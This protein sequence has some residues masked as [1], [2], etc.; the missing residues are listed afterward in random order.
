MARPI[1]R[2]L[3]DPMDREVL[4]SRRS[5]GM[6]ADGLSYSVAGDLEKQMGQALA[7]YDARR[8][9]PRNDAFG[10][11]LEEDSPQN[12]R[13]E[14]IDPL[15]QS[16][17]GRS[18]QQPKSSAPRT[19]KVKGKNGEDIVIAIDPNTG[20]Q[21]IAYAGDAPERED[22]IHRQTREEHDDAIK[23][24]SKSVLDAK[25][26]RQREEAHKALQ[27]ARGARELFRSTPKA[28]A[29]PAPAL[30]SPIQK[31]LESYGYIGDPNNVRESPDGPENVFGTSKKYSR[32]GRIP[33]ELMIELENR[34]GGDRAVAAKWA[35]QSG[36]SLE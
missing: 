9:A 24:A 12:L 2:E 11:I 19:F 33:K 18:P 3:A 4:R 36:Y 13:Q 29:A 31:P 8:K 34:A 25:T 22:P 35:I 23:I 20:E 14:L 30:E 10:N 1:N 17:G 27:A 26:P 5:D 15:T 28:A 21:S 32:N 6:S 7:E 16:F